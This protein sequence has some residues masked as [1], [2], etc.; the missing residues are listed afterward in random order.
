ML[1]SVIKE[2]HLTQ[3]GLKTLPNLGNTGVR[4]DAS[5]PCIMIPILDKGGRRPENFCYSGFMV[6]AFIDWLLL[7]GPHQIDTSWDD[8]SP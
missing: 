5:A 7:Q 1:T 3:L 6:M 8:R 2:E 4:T